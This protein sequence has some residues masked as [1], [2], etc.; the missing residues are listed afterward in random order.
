MAEGRYVPANGRFLPTALYDRS[1]AI[2]MREGAWR[3]RLVRDVLNGD[4]REVLDLGCGTGTL[5]I[6]MA[7][8]GGRARITGI[9]GDAEILDIARAK[10][11]SEG[12]DFVG[13]LADALPFD[14]G[15]FDRVV[16]SLLLHHLDPAVKRAALAEARRV[17][18]RGG[19]LHVADFGRSHDPL[20]RILFAGL[21]VLDGFA[22]TAD[23]PAGRLPAMIETAGF[24]SVERTLALRTAWGSFEVLSADR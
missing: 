12:I 10:E 16:C 13:G 5:A 8:A 18:R 11:G 15:S 7:R 22:N 23:H 24:H 9:D 4:P 3:P 21:Q 14:D 1:I 17:L 2:T 20:M 6:A 19:R